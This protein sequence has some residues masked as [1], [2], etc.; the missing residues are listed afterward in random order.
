MCIHTQAQETGGEG[1]AYVHTCTHAH[2]GP[3]GE[4]H[5]A[6]RSSHGADVALTE[7]QLGDRNQ[8]TGGINE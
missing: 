2:T 3:G 8:E 5:R 4:E 1:S 6:V 7:E